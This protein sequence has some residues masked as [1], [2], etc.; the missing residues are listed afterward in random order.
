MLYAFLMLSFLLASL[1]CNQHTDCNQC[2]WEKPIRNIN[3]GLCYD[4]IQKAINAVETKDNHTILV[5]SGIYSEQVV[6]N[7]SIS[8]I[9]ANMEKTILERH[10]SMPVVEVTCN[11]VFIK[12][13]T[14]RNTDQHAYGIKIS[15]SNSSFLANLTIKDTHIGIII[16]QSNE[17]EISN[18]KIENSSIGILLDYSTKNKL[19]LNQIIGCVSGIRLGACSEQNIIGK[20]QIESNTN[21]IELGN[22]ADFNIFLNNYLKRNENGVFFDRAKNCTFIGNVLSYNQ[23]GVNLFPHSANNTFF[24]NSFFFNELQV[25]YPYFEEINVWDGNYILGGNFWSDYTGIDNKSGQ[26]QNETGSD[27]I[28]DIPYNITS[29]NRDNYPLTGSFIKIANASTVDKEILFLGASANFTI[30]E[31]FLIEKN[32]SIVIKTPDEKVPFFCRIVIPKDFLSREYQG[33]NVTVNGQVVPNPSMEENGKYTLL[34]FEYAYYPDQNAQSS[35]PSFYI[36][37]FLIFLLSSFFIIIRM[38]IVGKSKN[39]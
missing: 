39:K 28:G 8:L 2:E 34:F 5:S 25:F 29:Q 22:H 35:I 31:L 14:I 3:T 12:N 27:G 18:T 36:V 21:G 33:L 26:Y 15:R 11:N 19:F 13:F 38:F 23:R 30:K 24:H 1:N 6:I 37:A 9:G 20:N 16:F 17:N 7:K 4:S 32:N 10:A